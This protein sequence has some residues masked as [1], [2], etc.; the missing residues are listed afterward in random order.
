LVR[1]ILVYSLE[2]LDKKKMKNKNWPEVCLDLKDIECRRVT[3][4][5]EKIEDIKKI[6]YDFS[7]NQIKKIDTD[8][9]E[10]IEDIKKKSYPL[11]DLK[12]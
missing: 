6:H 5:E 7:L 12:K 11:V 9:K 2:K 8:K 4:K 1:S 3:N 10:K